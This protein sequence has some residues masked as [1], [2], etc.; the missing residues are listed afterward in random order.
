MYMNGEVVGGNLEKADFTDC[1]IW[2]TY[3]N[4]EVLLSEIEGYSFNHRFLH[5]IVKGGDWDEDPMFTNPQ[6]DDYT[7]QEGSP[8]EGIGYQFPSA[9]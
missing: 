1:I 7:L 4:G 3:Y 6:E 2:G 8:A 5:S 9:N